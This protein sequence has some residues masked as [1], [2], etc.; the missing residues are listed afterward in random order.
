M[1]CF[2][3]KRPFL[4]PFLLVVLLIITW[5]VVA[6]PQLDEKFYQQVHQFKVKIVHTPDIKPD[7]V[8][9]ELKILSVSQDKKTETNFTKNKSDPVQTTH[10]RS[11]E[12]DWIAYRSLFFNVGNVYLTT[13]HESQKNIFYA[14]DELEF[15]ARLKKPTSFKNEGVF[16]YEKYL[17]KRGIAA[18][19]YLDDEMQLVQASSAQVWLR[20][21]R[22]LKLSLLDHLKKIDPDMAPLLSAIVW[23][24]DSELS[25][26]WIDLFRS[27]G[28][29]HLIVVSGMHFAALS[30][31]AYLILDRLLRFFP[32][33]FI[34]WPRQ[35][36]ACL[37]SFIFITGFYILCP[38][39]PSVLRGFVATSCFLI[40]K[41]VNRKSDP[42]NILFLAATLILLFQ[43]EDLYHPSFQFSFA[44]VFSLISLV[45]FMRLKEPLF[46]NPIAHGFIKISWDLVCVQMAI[47]LGLT[48]LQLFYFPEYSLSGFWMNLV[49]V[50]WIEMLVVPLGFMGLVFSIFFGF[51]TSLFQL[52][53]WLLRSLVHFLETVSG[54]FDFLRWVYPPH[55]YELLVY[56]ALLIGVVSFKAARRFK[57]MMAIFFVSLVYVSVVCVQLKLPFQDSLTQID[58]GQGDS[59]LIESRAGQR[60]LVDG[61][62]HP[63]IDMGQRVLL[64]YLLHRRIPKIDIIVVTH[65]DFDH[66][67]GL[68]TLIENYNVG[69]V[70]F[71]GHHSSEAS[72][73]DFLNVIRQKNILLREVS[74]GQVYFMNDK[75]SVEIFGPP[76]FEPRQIVADNDRSVVLRWSNPK[77]SALLTGDMEALGESRLIREWGNKLKSDILKI[78]HHGSK[79]STSDEFLTV[80]EPEIALIG[81]GRNNRF[82]HPHSGVIQ[83]LES[84]GVVV[85]RTDWEGEIKISQLRE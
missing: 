14:G 47:F 19:V 24:D 75:Q 41:L 23:G 70:W 57:P 31:I 48:P 15:S 2:F 64:P 53:L 65:A 21:L 37:G 39:S 27:H 46:N 29:S 79:T 80:V 58:V 56:Y 61:G 34:Y 45:P 78:G 4:I 35:K 8:G 7:R 60:I 13:R 59:L 22:E 33:L 74:A 63:F 82:R 32:C 72:W 83:R 73:Q 11:D 77:F 85:R 81:V 12:K 50:P 17:R 44:A 52:D 43:P 36:W 66:Y 25:E 1:I 67:G 62:G 55:F 28:L 38:D 69:E 6:P 20:P 49:A 9:Y 30:W 18:T 5:Q 84:R 68:K 71:N 54:Q 51:T 40:A 42:L 10:L 16:D 76:V 3:M 26:K